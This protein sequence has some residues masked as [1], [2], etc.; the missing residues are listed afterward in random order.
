MARDTVKPSD[1]SPEVGFFDRFAGGVATFVSR[2]PFFAACCIIVLIWLVQ[3]FVTVAVKGWSSFINPTYQ[4]EINTTTTIIT[5]LMVAIVQNTTARDSTATQAKM[6]ALAD[7]L[8][9]LIEFMADH[10]ETKSDCDHLRRD[11]EELRT[12]VGLETRTST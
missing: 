4:L 12:A 9:D 1:V 2:A 7:G 8:A 3:G 5:F 10:T 11:A 6:N